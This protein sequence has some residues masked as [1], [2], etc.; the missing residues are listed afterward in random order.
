MSRSIIL[1]L[2]YILFFPIVAHAGMPTV[3][4]TLTQDGGSRTQFL[5]ADGSVR[6]FTDDADPEFLKL[7]AAGR[8]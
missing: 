6:T 7:T 2:P 5:I 3:T 1:P 4:V 8:E